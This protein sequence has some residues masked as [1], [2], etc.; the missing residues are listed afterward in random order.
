MSTIKQMQNEMYASG[1]NSQNHFISL[2]EKEGYKCTKANSY[3]DKVEHWD[4]MTEKDGNVDYIDVKSNKEVTKQ[5]YTWVEQQNVEGNT[6]WLYGEKL[7]AIAF[8]KDDRFDIVDVH[9]L[10]KLI[11]EKIK[12]K[13]ELV[14]MKPPDLKDLLYRRYR[15]A[16]RYDIVILT[17]FEDID[18]L[19][20]KTVYK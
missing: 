7:T 4:V 9:G 6:G 2:M 14:F 11:D 16:G 15:R 5:G 19:I 20:I 3:E 12:D 10:R 17:P 18:K 13:G 1:V 8:E